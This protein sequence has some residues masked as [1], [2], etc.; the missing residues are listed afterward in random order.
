MNPGGIR[1]LG[2]MMLGAV[3]GVIALGLARLS[4]L[5]DQE[6]S[7]THY[8]ANWAV[9]VRGER[10]DLSA[11]RYME[12]VYR[13]KADPTRVDPEDRVH[14]HNGEHD[15]VH[16]H[17]AGVTWGHFLSNLGFSLG[18]SHLF[19][20]TQRLESTNE[21]TLKFVLNGQEVSSIHNLLIESED[22][23]LISFGRESATEVVETQFAHVAA[24]AAEYNLLPDPGG[25]GSV[26]ADEPPGALRRAFWF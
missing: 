18:D 4:F 6:H 20:D 9:F 14:M 5:P 21:E 2:L 11:Q 15:V 16:V 25:C 23:L 1:H 3:L 8:H 24:N 7:D 13:C 22:R 26:E 19:T 12:D 17:H 10:L